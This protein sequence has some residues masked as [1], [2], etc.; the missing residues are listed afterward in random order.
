MLQNF[1]IVAAS[2]EQII[3]LLAQAESTIG[4]LDTGSVVT[5]LA[6]HPIF[7]QVVVNENVAGP[8]TIVLHRDA[9]EKFS[10]ALLFESASRHSKN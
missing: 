6:E 10:A 2:H 8:S 3:N 7:G 5:T 9:A 1:T 4:T